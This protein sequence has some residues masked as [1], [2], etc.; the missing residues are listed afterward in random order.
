LD[1][2]FAIK[3]Y[4][5]FQSSA[6]D[7]HLPTFA[8][9]A[10]FRHHTSSKAV[11][12]AKVKTDQPVEIRFPGSAAEIVAAILADL[13]LRGRSNRLIDRIKNPAVVKRNGVPKYL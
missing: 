7:L 10:G 8:V 9:P 11:A 2:S 3:F 13:K 6:P 5:Y 1:I 4:W 12:D